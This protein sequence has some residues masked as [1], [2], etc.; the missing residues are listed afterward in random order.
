MGWQ[1]GLELLKRGHTV[2]ATTRNW[3][4]PGAP[5]AWAGEHA[6]RLE[7]ATLDVTSETD[8]RDVV[9]D[10]LARHGRVDTLINNAG[11]GLL[12]TMECLSA[13]KMRTSFETNVLGALRVAQAVLPGMRE[14][15]AGHIINVGSIFCTQHLAPGI[16]FYVGTKSAL[17]KMC[18]SLAVEVAPWGIRVSHFEPPGVTTELTRDFGAWPGCGPDPYAGV[19]ERAY[20]WFNE[21]SPD[22]QTPAEAG[23]SL[24][25][26][27]VMADPPFNFQSTAPARAFVTGGPNGPRD[28]TGNEGLATFVDWMAA[29]P[30]PPENPSGQAIRPE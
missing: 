22:F 16:G 1:A 18:E 25:G 24:A 4:D 29:H 6:A 27:A 28:P 8:A 14:R 2:I 12:G 13:E 7:V 5:K 17:K 15:E 26:L 10:A 19:V 30:D 3:K 23:A 9:M 20:M 11:I 21:A